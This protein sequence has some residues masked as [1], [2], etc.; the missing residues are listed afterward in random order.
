[1]AVG[2]NRDEK[3]EYFVAHMPSSLTLLSGYLYAKDGAA[4]LHENGGLILRLTKPELHTLLESLKGYTQSHQLRAVNN[5][6]E[7]DDKTPISLTSPNDTVLAMS[8][9]ATKFFN[10]KVHV[11]TLTDRI[12]TLLLSGLSFNDWMNHV[13]NGSLG[14][15]P[16]DVTMQALNHFERQYGKTPDIIRLAAPHRI[17]NRSGLM[18]KD[19]SI[20][21]VGSRVEMDIFESDYNDIF[22]HQKQS[23]PPDP[24]PKKLKKLAS[25]GKA[26]AVAVAVDSYSGYTLTNLLKTTANAEEFIDKFLHHFQNASHTVRHIAADQG[27]IST[28]KFDIIPPALRNKRSLLS[29]EV[30]DCGH[31][32]CGWHLERQ[33]LS[34]STMDNFIDDAAKLSLQEPCKGIEVRCE[35]LSLAS[36]G[37]HREVFQLLRVKAL[38]FLHQNF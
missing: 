36:C 14:G 28:T 6:Y 21:A 4:I 5:T 15:I 32:H 37:E 26:V 3:R 24:P 22:V 30:I 16:P 29:R 34:W 31:L 10:T 8:N 9:T 11:S 25:H 1:V 20:T 38:S 35:V 19:T 23:Q 17:G 33:I 12:L 27:V 13:Q 7:F 18:D 2:I